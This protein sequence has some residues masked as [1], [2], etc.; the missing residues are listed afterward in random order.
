MKIRYIYTVV[1]EEEISNDEAL[2]SAKDYFHAIKDEAGEYLYGGNGC[3]EKI[4]VV[5]QQEISPGVWVDSF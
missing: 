1:R 4:E 3:H 2:D 5:L